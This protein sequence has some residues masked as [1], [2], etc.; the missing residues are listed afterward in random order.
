MTSPY[1]EYS[2][3]LKDRYGEKVYKLPVNMPTTC[4]NRDG[5]LGYGGCT[6]C[7]DVAAG[8]ESL[9]SSMGVREQI[10]RNMTYIGRK[11]KAEKFIAYFQNFTNTYMDLEDFKSMIEEALMEH[12]L[13]I[14]ISTRPDAVDSKLLDYLSKLRETRGIPITMEY[15]LQSINP[16]TLRAI[17]RGHGLGEFI[18]AVI[19]TR[20]R[21][22]GVCV[23]MILNLP[24]DTDLEAVESAKILSALSV[25][26]VKLHSLYIL[27]NTPMGKAYQE[28]K[29]QLISKDQYI[30]RVI[31]FLRHLSEEIAVQRLL[32]R[33]PEQETLFCNWSQSWWRI[34]DEIHAKMVEKGFRQGD[35]RKPLGMTVLGKFR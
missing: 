31:L 9:K 20:E 21:G 27:K 23:H 22:L 33:A 17:N 29:I 18:E 32:A 2:Q 12:V 35:L 30:D 19:M 13:E 14:S 11:Y 3:Y 25:D 4:P 10:E 8:F 1:Y 5:V 24:G 15:G 34:K 6:F 16:H 28:G 7:G 26:F